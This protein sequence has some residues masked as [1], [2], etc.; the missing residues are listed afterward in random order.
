VI[1]T[2]FDY[3]RATSLDDALAKLRAAKGDAKLIAGGHSLVPL[4]KLRL[5]EP[6]ALI[7]IAR[8]PGLAGI[9]KN[10]DQIEIGAGTV[11]HDVATSAL[12]RQECPMVSDA[13]AS[14]GD[15]QVRNRGTLGGSLAHA[16][17]AADY[18]AVMLALDAGIQIL[19]AK[20]TRTV[21]AS[22]FFRGMF[23]VDLESDEI[24]TGVQFKP[25]KA[26]AY[27]KLYQRASHFA[28][29]GVAAVLE[30]KNGTIQSARIGVTGAATHA[31]RLTGLEQALAG[32]STAKDAIAAATKGAGAA[33]QDVNSDL[34]ASEEYR[35][36]MIPVFAERAIAEAA[37]R[38]T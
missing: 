37:A 28:I 25:V 8:I 24:I 18:P 10:G 23:T 4:M 19:G 31:Q 29:V 27:A 33:V 13:A 17:P 26:A 20:G 36:A 1:S 15:P 9:R 34:H 11:H 12:L 2:A 30:V 22:D 32:K 3:S 7:D 5:S 16:D 35:R 38:A 14:I 21:K 6:K